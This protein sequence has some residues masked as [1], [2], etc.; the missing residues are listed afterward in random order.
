MTDGG[1]FVQIGGLLVDR[2]QIKLEIPGIYHFAFR[3]VENDAKAIR[4]AVVRL[5]KA[6][7]HGAQC[8]LGVAVDLHQ[9]C[10]LQQAVLF[11]LISISP[12]VRRVPFCVLIL[13]HDLPKTM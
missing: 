9:L 10:L 4:N 1:H 7:G 8:E 5:K 6:G 13:N 12:S 11:S 2:G 3:R